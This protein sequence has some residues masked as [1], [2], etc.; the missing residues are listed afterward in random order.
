MVLGCV[1]FSEVVVSIAV[2]SGAGGG[3]RVSECP[4]L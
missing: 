4:C 1:L 3:P 2:V